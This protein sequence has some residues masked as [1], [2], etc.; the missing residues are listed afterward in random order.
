MTV[1]TQ[2]AIETLREAL[3]DLMSDI[4]ISRLNSG[5]SA[6]A[7]LSAVEADLRRKDE[8]L[9]LAE[10][11]IAVFERDDRHG[12]LEMHQEDALAEYASAR[13]ALAV[14]P[15]EPVPQPE[16]PVEWVDLR[17]GDT[18]SLRVLDH[19]FGWVRERRT[20]VAVHDTVI[21]LRDGEREY[22]LDYDEPERY[23]CDLRRSEPGTQQAED[24]PS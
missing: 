11:L 9:K 2:P 10:G 3:S 24:V 18:I 17:P 6:R 16:T 23:R 20:V 15:S 1:S 21:R 19:Q 14:S 4:P 7:A 12:N 5:A 22:D 8:V 13:A